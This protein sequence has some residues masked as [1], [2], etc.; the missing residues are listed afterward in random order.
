MSV[1]QWSQ[2]AAN[3]A[4]SDSSIN[5]REGMAPSAVNDSARAMM[6]AIACFRDDMSGK[7]VTSGTSTAYTLSSNQNISSGLIDGFSITF[8]INVINGTP[9]TLNVDGTGAKPVKYNSTDL[10]AGF[11][12]LNT[13]YSATY[14]TSLGQW[15]MQNVPSFGSIFSSVL[16]GV[17]IDYFDSVAPAGYVMASGRSI[18]SAS[19]GAT[20]RA[21]ADTKNLYLFLWNTIGGLAVAGGRGSGATADFNANKALSL[22]DLRGRVTIGQDDMG[23]TAAHVI[24][25]FSAIFPGAT[26]GSQNHSLTANEN[27]AHSHTATD[28]GHTHPYTDYH[29]ASTG[30]AGGSGFLVGGSTSADTTSTGYANIVVSTSGSGSGHN[31]I[32]PSMVVTKI[33]KL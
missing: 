5:W 15:V 6:A 32:Q 30:G 20:E 14:F 29:P 1:S 26:G 17:C 33:I 11:L 21:N 19:S 8:R 24:T 18:G 4:T 28:Q 7:L 16:T 10:P 25:N 23:G 13:P 3:N 31:N 27:G 2:T 12:Q 9:V 22:P